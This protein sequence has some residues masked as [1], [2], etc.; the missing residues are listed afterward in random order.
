MRPIDLCALF[1]IVFSGFIMQKLE[2]E[3]LQR[4]I[5]FKST[6]AVISCGLTAS[7]ANNVQHEALS[8]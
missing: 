2:L 4:V 7:S 8:V 1:F 3:H 5:M 6:Q